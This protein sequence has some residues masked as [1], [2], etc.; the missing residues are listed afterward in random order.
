MMPRQILTDVITIGK[1]TENIEEE[2][3]KKFD[4]EIIRWAIVS[5]EGERIKVCCSYKC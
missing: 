4:A 5:V 1:D 2:L 3:H